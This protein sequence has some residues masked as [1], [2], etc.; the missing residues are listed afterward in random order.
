MARGFHCV[1]LLVALLSRTCIASSQVGACLNNLRMIEGAKELCQMERSMKVGDPVET[2]WLTNNLHA[3]ALRCPG[4]GSYTIGPI[5]T[6][7]RCSIEL[8]SEAGLRRYLTDW[9]NRGIVLS[10]AA[11]AAMVGGIWFVFAAMKRARARKNLPPLGLEF[12]LASLVVA[13]VLS[14]LVLSS[15]WTNGLVDAPVWLRIVFLPFGLRAAR[16]L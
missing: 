13:Y 3:D 6:S 10:L 11:I 7:P 15:I 16:W 14:G 1:L 12:L 9:R 8:H 5:G 2:A 4:G